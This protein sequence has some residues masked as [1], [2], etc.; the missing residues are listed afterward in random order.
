MSLIELVYVSA[1]DH[2]MTK[3]ELVKVLEEARDNNQ[4]INV[5]GMLLYR[6][7]FFL[8]VLEGEREVVY[9]LYADIAKD[10]RH[11]HVLT[12]EAADIQQRS[13]PN[14]TMGFKN[15]ED[16]SETEMVGF[17]KFL[18]EPFRPET[19]TNDPSRARRMLESF[20]EGLYF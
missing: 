14:W 5:T 19:F 4:K 8:Q 11:H 10:P 2:A 1:A 16:L 6:D 20:K 12:V 18:D 9:A 13:F 17:S 7:G 15:L 3:E